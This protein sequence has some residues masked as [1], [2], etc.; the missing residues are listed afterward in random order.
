MKYLFLDIL[1][2]FKYVL[3]IQTRNILSFQLL[4]EDVD[5]C[6]AAS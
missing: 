5:K 1:L 2:T 6:D 3:V 4:Q